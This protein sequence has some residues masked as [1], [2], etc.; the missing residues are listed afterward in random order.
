[1][2]AAALNQIVSRP[3][4]GEDDFQRVRNLLIETYPI[5][6]VGF[7]WE[8]RRWDGWRYY[9]EDTRITPE[10]SQRIRL[11]E[12][13][14]GRLVGVAH[15]EYDGSAF[16][17]LDPD[18]RDL[19]A[20]M[21]EWAEAN[22]AVTTGDD[23]ARWLQID[24]LDYDTPHKRLLIE[25]GYQLTAYTFVTRRLRFGKR[26]LPQPEVAP[27]YRLRNTQHND[28][29]YQRMADVVNAG[30]GSSMNTPSMYRSF[31]TGSPSFEHDL[32]LVAEA[33]DGTF[34]AHVGLTHD[35]ANCRGIV[36]PVCTH[37]DHRRKGLARALIV[38]GLH[39]LRARGATDVYV[40]SGG[41]EAANALYDEVGFNEAYGGHV[42]RKTI[43]A[44]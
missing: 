26:P 24:A 3:F 39:R 34:V 43:L 30:F 27:G 5:T 22:L 42:W 28:A 17:E 32:N 9:R 13:T 4:A 15:P 16:F 44:P 14:D 29:D 31:A 8:I 40:D 38:E 12:T 7:N 18:Y 21:I 23:P 33:A 35:A 41:A 2:N 37:P 36:E 1:M 25:R 20:E 19:E 11:W 10:W 6:P